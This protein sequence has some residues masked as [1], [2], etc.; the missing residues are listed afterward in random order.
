MSAPTRARAACARR[1]TSRSS[2]SPLLPVGSRARRMFWPTDIDVMRLNSW[3]T[4][5][6][7]RLPASSRP[8]TTAGV[9]LISSSPAS[10][11]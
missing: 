7:A 2:I 3:N 11:A 5:A 8:R 1:R 4:M 10:P 9:P 6:I